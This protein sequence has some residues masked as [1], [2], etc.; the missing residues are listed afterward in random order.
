MRLFGTTKIRPV[1][2]AG[3]WLLKGNTYLVK[4]RHEPQEQAICL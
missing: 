1:K 3:E 4:E 2:L